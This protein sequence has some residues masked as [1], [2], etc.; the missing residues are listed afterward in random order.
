MDI[1][2][3][4]LQFPIQ[5]EWHQKVILLYISYFK[6]N[7]NKL[8]FGIGAPGSKVVICTDGMSNVGEGKFEQ[9][10]TP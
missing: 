7:Y 8:I 2:P 5:L 6:N 9:L 10:E 3:L 1:Q 4:V